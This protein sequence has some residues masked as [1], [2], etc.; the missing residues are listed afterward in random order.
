MSAGSVGG[1]WG[2]WTAIFV[3]PYLVGFISFFAPAGLGMRELAMAEALQRSGLAAGAL[4][5]L[6]VLASRVWLTLLEII[7]GVLLLLVTPRV[8]TDSSSK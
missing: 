8:R 2:E 6:L 3:G 7:P 4:A 1:T 5:A